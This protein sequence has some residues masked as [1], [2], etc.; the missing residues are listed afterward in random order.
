MVRWSAPRTGRLARLPSRNLPLAR[1][2]QRPSFMRPSPYLGARFWARAGR[3]VA[4]TGC[5]DFANLGSVD[6]GGDAG[7]D[8]TSHSD[9][10]VPPELACTYVRVPA[11]PSLIDP[12]HWR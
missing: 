3:S 10:N 11:A 4:S 5:R 2:W 1:R 8:S 9:A 12:D 7:P 6:Q